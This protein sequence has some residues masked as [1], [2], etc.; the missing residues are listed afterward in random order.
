MGVEVSPFG[1]WLRA[2]N[3]SFQ[4]GLNP[5]LLLESD[6]VECRMRTGQS[7]NPTID[8]EAANQWSS[9][10]G[11]GV[12]KSGQHVFQA[13]SDTWNELVEYEK[14]EET[15]L[16][17]T[18]AVHDEVLTMEHHRDFE[19]AH[20]KSLAND[21]Q[22][23]KVNSISEPNLVTALVPF[24][25]TLA[26]IDPYPL[27]DQLPGPSPYTSQTTSKPKRK[28]IIL[29]HSDKEPK[30]IKLTPYNLIHP[31][32]ISKPTTPPLELLSQPKIIQSNK[33]Y[34]KAAKRKFS[35]KT[36]GREKAQSSQNSSARL[37]IIPMVASPVHVNSSPCKLIPLISNWSKRQALSSPTLRYEDSGM[38]LLGH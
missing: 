19:S 11:V 23:T 32:S 22:S 30:K 31:H 6:R 28:D 33:V 15:K 35:L 2:N 27:P 38:E 9:Q 34:H 4:L 13:A 21:L 20:I 36:Q 5:N 29:A 16:A 18:V 24:Q 17:M 26:H 8:E 1:S 12:E 25:L 10:N 3:N 37:D 14:I 7:L